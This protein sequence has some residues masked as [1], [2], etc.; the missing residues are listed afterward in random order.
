MLIAIEYVFIVITCLL[1]GLVVFG[2]INQ[3]LYPF[4]LYGIAAGMVLMTTLAGPHLV[5][6]DVHLDYYYTRLYL[7][8]NV[9]PPLRG[10]SQ[11]TAI[12]NTILAPLLIKL[13]HMPSEWIFKLVFPLLFSTTP[14]ILYYVY[15]QWLNEK[16]SFLSSIVFI[17]V[18]TFFMEIPG[19]PREMIAEVLLAATLFII[20]ASNMKLRYRIPS[21]ILCGVLTTMTHYTIGIF[22]IILLFVGLVAK[23]CL[24]VKLRIPTWSLAF[25]LLIISIFSIIYIGTAANGAVLY[26]ISVI[27]NGFAPQ[28]LML[29]IERPPENP[30]APS[31]CKP[32]FIPFQTQSTSGLNTSERFD[33]DRNEDLMDVAL[34]FDFFRV[35]LSGKIF[36]ILQWLL[37]IGVLVGMIRWRQNKQ[38]W[39][40]AAGA[41]LLLALCVLIP[42]FSASLNA[43]RFYHL[44]LF[45]LAPITVVGGLF[46]LQNRQ[47]FVL[48]L[49]IPY[50]L[51]SSGFIFEITKQTDISYINIPY[52]IGLSDRRID[53][54]ATITDNDLAVVKWMADSQIPFPVY[55]DIFGAFI[56]GEDIGQR[57]Y[58]NQGFPKYPQEL[59]N[60][61][62]YVF[63]RE[64]NVWDNCLVIRG[65]TG[66]RK[67]R[68]FD[69]YKVDINKGII[70]QVGDARV[71]E[72]R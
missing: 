16:D 42:G 1:I 62:Y 5:G 28:G 3:R 31:P 58:I 25:I 17:I 44:S 51:F 9:W 34:G 40:F 47:L 68:P 13:F 20:I 35:P 24:K 57:Y 66:C 48:C 12:G 54:G 55:S 43:S 72:V 36:R 37:G 32:T 52:N 26:K 6:S 60:P 18:P 67:Y 11:E 10:T 71:L 21:S 27:Y 56:I 2:R 38:F 49:I 59:I 23:L 63:I 53:L 69:E 39:V 7:G 22:L 64:R 41:L 70:Y 15:R 14:V 45:I 29:N 65:A 8:D 50:F 19:I 46:L 30:N 4:I 61:P 33:L